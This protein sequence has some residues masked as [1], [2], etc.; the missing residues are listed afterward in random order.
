M[1]LNWADLFILT[2][3]GISAL[4]SLLRGLVREVLSL[5]GWVAACWVAFRFSGPAGQVLAGTFGVPPSVR[6]A[7]GFIALLVCVLLA[8][9]IVNFL[10]GK[11]IDSTGLG[12]TD[13]M[14][15]MLFGIGRGLAII[16]VLV[17]F[18]GLTPLPRD[19]WWHQSVFLPRLEPAARWAIGW[20]PAEFA[21]HF[22]NYERVPPAGGA[23]ASQS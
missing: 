21:K 4:L 13:K 22:D 23:S 11:L 9:G 1:A 20:L 10:I 7:I 6:T 12:G 5:V 3:L 17:I 2:V 16:T 14:L 19:P 8:F 18:A 15:G